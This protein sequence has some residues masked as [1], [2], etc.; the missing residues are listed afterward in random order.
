[1]SLARSPLYCASNVSFSA[2]VLPSSASSSASRVP[3]PALA[4]AWL[5]ESG[6]SSRESRGTSPFARPFAPSSSELDIILVTRQQ[7]QQD[8]V[9]SEESSTKSRNP[10]RVNKLQLHNKLPSRLHPRK[11][12][13]SSSVHPAHEEKKRYQANLDFLVTRV[14]RGLTSGASCDPSIDPLF[15][16]PPR[17]RPLTLRLEEL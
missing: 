8:S 13:F 10:F 14:K 6:R 7:F 2:R 4:S 5:G 15:A 3:S 17:Q 1:M 11:R 16:S 9:R 12:Q